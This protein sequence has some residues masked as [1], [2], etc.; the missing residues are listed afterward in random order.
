MAY[1]AAAMSA[2]SAYGNMQQG[3]ATSDALNAQA[4]LQLQNAQE[5]LQQ[6]KFDATR[7]QLI[8]T[9]QI[10]EITANYGASG[11]SNQSGSVLDVL[12]AS[13]A[14]AELDRLN[15]L[16]GAD[17]RAI[18]Y[19]NQATLDKMGATSALQGSYYNAA[20]NVASGAARSYGYGVSANNAGGTGNGDTTVN[21]A[22]G[23]QP[24]SYSL[25]NYY[26]MEPG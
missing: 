6:G 11:V 4:N 15:I 26:A 9:K 5:S 7:S 23:G 1:A 25:S 3:W 19:E 2:V 13:A 8:S 22:P 17:I 12:G 16:H 14:N 18:N 21:A 20:A 10:G 24:G